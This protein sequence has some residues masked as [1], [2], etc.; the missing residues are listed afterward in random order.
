MNDKYSTGHGESW[1]NT[2]YVM[3]TVVRHIYMDD[4]SGVTKFTIWL[5]MLEEEA[6]WSIFTATCLSRRSLFLW[7]SQ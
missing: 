4:I 5:F 1:R 3:H 7:S 6:I 2:L